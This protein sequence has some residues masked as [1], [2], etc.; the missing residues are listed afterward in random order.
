MDLGCGPGHL[1]HQLAARGFRTI[2]IDGSDAMLA[3][4]RE[5]LEQH[6][7]ADADLRRLTLPLPADLVDELAGQA[8]LIVMSSVI[9]YIDGD[10]EMLRQCARLLAPG[11]HLLASFPNRRALLLAAAAPAQADSV[12]RPLGIAPPT[13]SVRRGDGPRDGARSRLGVANRHVFRVAAAAVHGSTRVRAPTP[14]RDAVPRGSAADEMT[15]RVSAGSPAPC[16]SDPPS[17]EPPA[18]RRAAQPPCAPASASSV[19][20]RRRFEPSSLSG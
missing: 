14:R 19:G 13:T 17:G 18:A 8:Q 12:V 9:E 3:R 2:S 20:R 5:R 15:P 11:G 7:I 10:K 16:G 4:T 6:G 1:T